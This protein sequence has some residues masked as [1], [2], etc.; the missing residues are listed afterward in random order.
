VAASFNEDGRGGKRNG[1]ET[2]GDYDGDAG[3]R[4]LAKT[5]FSMTLQTPLYHNNV[6]GRLPIMDFNAGLG[7]CGHTGIG[8]GARCFYDVTTTVGPDCC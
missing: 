6:T 2:I 3:A 1:F 5:N 8:A 7:P 4:I